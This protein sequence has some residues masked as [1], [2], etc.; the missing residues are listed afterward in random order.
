MIHIAFLTALLAATV[1]S[2]AT[3]QTPSR[4]PQTRLREVL[5]AG[6][7][8][9]VIDRIA[10]AR[11]REL[12]A[13]ALA[14]RALKFAAK[15]VPPREIAKSVAEQADRMTAVKA[16]L[17]RTRG[18]RAADGEVEAGAEALRQGVSGSAVAELARTA[19]S[20]RSLEVPLYV[21]GSLV[22]RG[23]PSDEAL[24]RVQERLTSRA[25]DAELER[26]PGTLPEQ[27]AG[28]KGR[29]AQT[30]RELAGTKRPGSAGAPGGAG[31]AG[32]PPAHVPAG[33]GKPAKPQKPVTPN[34]RP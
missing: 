4:D 15:G 3:G 28:G 11:Q 6:V 32:G 23:L 26:L 34:G 19:P 18:R 9:Q 20:G 25:T 5:P 13:D 24:K 30:G 17:D 1:A 12:P 7:A 27:A 33:R 22:E 21:I 14:Q 10:A 29:P 2:P 31:S 16:T 8:Q